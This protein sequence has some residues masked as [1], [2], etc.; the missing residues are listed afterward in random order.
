MSTLQKR[1]E[2]KAAGVES[3]T[4]TSNKKRKYIDYAREIPFQ[5][6]VPAG[7]YDVS[8]ENVEGKKSKLSLGEHGLKLS[9]MEGRHIREE[10]A[11]HQKKDAQAMKKL[12]KARFLT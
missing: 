1:R 8:E 10:E 7:M 2:L 12:F 9:E 6:I 3:K 4:S 5:K 11:K